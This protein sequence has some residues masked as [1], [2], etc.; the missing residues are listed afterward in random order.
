MF[1]LSPSE[2]PCPISNLLEIISAKWTVQIM[3]ELALQPTRTRRFLLHI[4]GLSMKTLSRR[5][6]IMEAAKLISRHECSAKPLKVE[7]RLTEFGEKLCA[8]LESVKA[9]EIEMNSSC[10]NCKCPVER[11]CFQKPELLDCPHRR[12]K[13]TKEKI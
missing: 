7:Y 11:E 8:I 5:L 2:L 9:L 6:Q 12:E 4:P 3:R 13:R 1:Q 10:L